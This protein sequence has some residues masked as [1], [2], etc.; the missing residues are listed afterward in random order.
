MNQVFSTLKKI[1]I[2]QVLTAFVLGMLLFVTQ[3]CSSVDAKTPDSSYE[4]GMNQYSD[5]DPRSKDAEA[6]AKIKAKALKDNAKLNTE[7]SGSLIGNTRRTLDNKAENLE[8][9]GKNVKEGARYATDEIQDSAEEFAEGTKRGIRNIKENTSDAFDSLTNNASDVAEEA[10]LTTQRAA[11]DAKLS[12]ERAARDAKLSTQRAAED[13]S[14]AV[15]R[16]LR[17]VVN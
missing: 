8:D 14:N 7:Q 2:K 12:T 16:T 1:Q 5:V 17:D 15:Q 13:A 4:G 11:K 10:K 3:A 6:A 9:L